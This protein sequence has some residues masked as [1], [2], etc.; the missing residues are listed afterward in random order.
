M[1]PDF[2]HHE[3][4]TLDG[5]AEARKEVASLKSRGVTR[6]VDLNRVNKRNV[7]EIQSDEEEFPDAGP[8]RQRPRLDPIPQLDSLDDLDLDFD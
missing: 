2:R 8:P 6:F 1:R 4:S 3:A 5:L 7:E